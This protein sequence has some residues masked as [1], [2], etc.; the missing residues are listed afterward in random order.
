MLEVK[1]MLR[2]VI[3]YQLDTRLAIYLYVCL[4]TSNLN[5]IQ[6]KE[7]LMYET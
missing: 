3:P 6:D 5:Y 4:K 7:I 1:I 2:C